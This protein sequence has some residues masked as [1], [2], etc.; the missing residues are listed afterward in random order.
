MISREPRQIVGFDAAYD[1][2]RT[3]I[4]RIVDNAPPAERYSTDGYLGYCD[5]D[6]FG[7]HIRNTK[8][9]A[10]THNV[11]SINADLRHYIPGLRRRSR[12]FHRT[13]ET[14]H[15]VLHVYIEAYNKF[16][17]AK[18]KLRI[19]AG[20]NAETTTAHSHKYREVPFSA[21]DFL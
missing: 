19:A 15:A 8:N 7:E 21:L 1:K 12:C 2:S 16:G 20:R 10:D 3:R 4:Q 18:M 13:L 17:E 14:L 9:K 5:I 11:E 6:Y